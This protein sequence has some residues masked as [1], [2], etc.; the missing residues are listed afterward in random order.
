MLRF[1]KAPLIA[2]MALGALMVWAPSASAAVRVG[3]G[4]R[5]G[6]GVY[7][8]GWYPAWGYGPAGYGFG[9]YGSPAGH[10]KIDTPDKSSS[11]FVDGGYVGPVAKNKK[12]PLRPGNHIVELRDPAGEVVYSEQVNVMRGRTVDIHTAPAAL[13]NHG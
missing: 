6:V 5:G 4:Y 13:P 9:Y 11:V 2:V 12:F 3:F 10:V 1:W 7:G 8:G